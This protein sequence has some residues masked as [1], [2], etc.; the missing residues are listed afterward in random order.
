MLSSSEVW[1]S[2]RHQGCW[3]ANRSLTRLIIFPIRQLILHHF[4]R[5]SPS[6]LTSCVHPQAVVHLANWAPH[7]PGEW[8]WRRQMAGQSARL[9]TARSPHPLH[10]E[11]ILI[12]RESSPGTL[13]SLDPVASRERSFRRPVR[14]TEPGDVK[15]RR[16]KLQ[17]QTTEGHSTGVEDWA[18]RGRS[19]LWRTCINR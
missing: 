8:F 13:N 12:A 1:E 11:S 19:S 9:C 17:G 10:L 2:C 15:M 18:L 14:M 3:L 7:T 5:R 16:W 4:H 6:G